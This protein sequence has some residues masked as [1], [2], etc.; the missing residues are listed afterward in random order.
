MSRDLILTDS[1]GN[2]YSFNNL[3]TQKWLE[4]KKP[5]AEAAASYL[6]VKATELFVAGKHAQ[7][8]E[9]QYLAKEMFE[10]VAEAF[11]KQAQEHAKDHPFLI[12]KETGK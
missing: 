4:G 5:G 11:T 6:V 9:M 2:Q 8:I 3:A 12:P 7:A 1:E 10:S